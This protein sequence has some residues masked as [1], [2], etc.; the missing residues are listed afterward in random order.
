MVYHDKSIYLPKVDSC[1]NTVSLCKIHKTKIFF[2][3]KKAS[4][5]QDLSILCCCNEFALYW[6]WIETSNQNQSL[7]WCS[8]R[9]LYIEKNTQENVP[10]S[11][12]L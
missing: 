8:A 11:G 12:I 1:Y 2:L 10:K 5:F 4:T 7:I 6:R 9:K 3:L